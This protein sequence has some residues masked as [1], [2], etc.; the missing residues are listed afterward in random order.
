MST[1]ELEVT[2]LARFLPTPVAV[3]TVRCPDGAVHGMTV[4]S[5]SSVSRTPAL[6]Q[7]CVAAR[8]ARHDLFVGADTVA[9]SVLTATQDQVA[10]DLAAPGGQQALQG[11]PRHAGLPVVPD[12]AG[13][14]VATVVARIAA[15]DHT[16]VLV[17]VERIVELDPATV[18]LIHWR[19][20]YARPEIGITAG[21]VGSVE[22]RRRPEHRSAAE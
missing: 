8:N 13:S 7:V 14:V 10:R 22:H 19:G 4:G 17:E 6:L 12:C 15:G 1:P 11:W 20:R 18:P 9:L 3:L 16:I 5:L 21:P 2:R